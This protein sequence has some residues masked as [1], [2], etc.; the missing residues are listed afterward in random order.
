MEG[1]FRARF[2]AF[3]PL[4]FAGHEA[5]EECVDVYREQ[6]GPDGK[7][8]LASKLLNSDG[9]C[10]PMHGQVIPRGWVGWGWGWGLIGAW[11]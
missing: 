5:G 10:G 4:C 6:L 2:H 3:Q 9:T 7:M 8:V 11:F 1:G